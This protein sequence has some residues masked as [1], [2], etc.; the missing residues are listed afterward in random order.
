MKHDI[1]RFILSFSKLCTNFNIT[2]TL[3]N[4]LKVVTIVPEHSVVWTQLEALYVNVEKDLNLP[5][6]D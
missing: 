5:M 4:V 2:Q 1:V 3:T 6:M